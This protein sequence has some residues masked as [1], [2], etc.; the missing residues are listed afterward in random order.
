M[1]PFNSALCAGFLILGIAVSAN[2]ALLSRLGGQAVYDTDLD[3]T[4]LADANAGAGSVF[5]DPGGLGG[6]TTDGKMTWSN[7]VAWA[8]SLTTGGF[9]DWRLPHAD[10]ACGF[11]VNCINS[12]MGHLFYNE[13]SGVV[14]DPII[15]SGDPDLSLFSNIQAFFSGDSYYWFG[16]EFAPDTSRAWIFSQYGGS[17]FADNK[18]LSI[19][20]WAVRDGDVGTTMTVSEPSIPALLGIGII[21]GWLCRRS[22]RAVPIPLHGG[23]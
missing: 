7:A 3:I 18:A 13:L 23:T 14:G 11:A 15:T 16:T 22:R 19:F 21:A 17:H 20:A 12:E 8:D 6:T 2:A 10:P 5:D 4:W 1:K 9:N